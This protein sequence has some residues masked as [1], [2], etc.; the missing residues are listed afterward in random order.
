MT[1]GAAAICVHSS[2]YSTPHAL[3]LRKMYTW[4]SLGLEIN[5]IKFNTVVTDEIWFS[6]TPPPLKNVMNCSS[7]FASTIHNIFYLFKDKR[8]HKWRDFQWYCDKKD[9]HPCLSEGCQQRKSFLSFEEKRKELV[10]KN[11]AEKPVSSLG[12]DLS[13]VSWWT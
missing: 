6:P 7:I 2:L 11:K 10:T 1:A 12:N 9:K 13:K 5:D 4:R 8:R 3:K